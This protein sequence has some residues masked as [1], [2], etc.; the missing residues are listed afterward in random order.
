MLK[1]KEQTAQNILDYLVERPYK[2]VFVLVDD[3][4]QVEELVTEE[5]PAPT[6]ETVA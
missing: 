4:R 2:E 5:Q 6:P 3:L 1:I